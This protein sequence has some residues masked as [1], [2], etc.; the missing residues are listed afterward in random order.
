MKP[1]K[2]WQTKQN[3]KHT[4][5]IVAGIVASGALRRGPK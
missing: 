1:N 3:P 4:A 5:A 2:K